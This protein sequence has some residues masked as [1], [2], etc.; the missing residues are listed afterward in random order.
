[1][2]AGGVACPKPPKRK[3][4]KGR[5]DRAEGKVKKSV[6]EQCVERDGWCRV[7]Q[8]RAFDRHGWGG[9]CFE[10]SSNLSQWAH[11]GE[12]TRAK[13][14]GQAPERR[15]TTGGSLMLCKAHHDALD[16]RSHP[17]LKITALT[18]NGCDGPLRFERF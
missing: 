7:G 9:L 4:V 5:K 14:R 17:R 18:D 6:R 16:G 1:M 15:H 2:G 3:T 11:W 10:C 13:T 12:H 8:Y